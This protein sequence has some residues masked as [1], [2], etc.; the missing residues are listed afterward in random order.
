M[1]LTLEDS[2]SKHAAVGNDEEEQQRKVTAR[3]SFNAGRLLDDDDDT[4]DWGNDSN[5][6]LSQSRDDLSQTG[7]DD[8][9]SFGQPSP[10]T[11][12]KAIEETPQLETLKQLFTP[13][14]ISPRK[15]RRE[16]KNKD[17]EGSTMEGRH[18]DSLIFSPE[19]CFK[20]FQEMSS[21]HSQRSTFTP[22]LSRKKLDQ[23]PRRQ[24]LSAVPGKR[25]SLSSSRLSM[26]K[27]ESARLIN[28]NFIQDSLRNLDF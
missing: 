10:V 20:E 18:R 1:S 15:I 28:K 21:N 9:Q 12:R 2:P 3:W 25:A 8:S 22:K 5:V 26:Q 13:E 19:S 27:R 16:R 7:D 6:K 14:Q 4:D 17:G 23:N 24:C 11:P